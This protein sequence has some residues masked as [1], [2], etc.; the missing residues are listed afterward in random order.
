MFPVRSDRPA[1]LSSPLLGLWL[2]FAAAL[3]GCAAGVL[4]GEIPLLQAGISL[5]LLAAVIR[6]TAS[7]LRVPAQPVPVERLQ[8]AWVLMTTLLVSALHAA[9][10]PAS[11]VVRQAVSGR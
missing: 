6:L 4:A 11:Y 7:A 1:P 3:L 5:L 2:A 9:K 8:Q 10:G